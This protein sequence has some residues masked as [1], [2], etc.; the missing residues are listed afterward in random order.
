MSTAAG[1]EHHWEW[2]WAPTA[3]VIG[4]FLLVPLGFSAYFVYEDTMLTILFTGLGTPI[5]LAGIARWVH[6]GL[7][8]K[9]L[10]AGLAATALPIFIVSEIFIFLGL[11]TAYWTMRLSQGGNWPPEGTPEL[12]LLIPVIMTF[13]LVGSSITYH[14]AEMKDE[15]GDMAGFRKWLI[16]TLILGTIFLGL[17]VY[18]YQHLLHIG[19]GPSANA[20]STAF[21]TITGFHASHVLVG[22]GSFLA[23]LIPAFKGRSN[24]T[25]TA[26]V[27]VY[28]HFVDVVWFFVA[29]QIYFW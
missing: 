16:I 15:A 5:L 8:Q 20:F 11:F 18:E 6:E 23:V 9:P 29:S 19:F 24:H 7:T 22:L 4:T 2:S 12:N 13:F 14:V 25:L 10:V 17:T 1:H 3:V 21:Y 28:W 26:S 27:G